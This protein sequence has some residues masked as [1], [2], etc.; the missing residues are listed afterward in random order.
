LR[1]FALNDLRS[2][3]ER[4]ALAPGMRAARTSGIAMPS[5]GMIHFT[6]WPARRLDACPPSFALD[7]LFFRDLSASESA[8]VI[9]HVRRCPRCQVE[10]SRRQEEERRFLAKRARERERRAA[11]WF[12]ARA[13]LDAARGRAEALVMHARPDR[14]WREFFVSLIQRPS[15]SVALVVMVA[16]A[17]F[18]AW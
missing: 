5:Q 1:R 14:G 2:I 4:T 17:V 3:A 8:A 6:A 10:L 15:F 13:V 7:R 18:S 9:A 11:Q 12:G 16:L